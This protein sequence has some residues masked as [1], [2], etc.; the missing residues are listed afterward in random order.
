VGCIPWILLSTSP[1][2]WSILSCM[3]LTCASLFFSTLAVLLGCILVCIQSVGCM[4]DGGSSTG[5]SAGSGVGVVGLVRFTVKYGFA[6]ILFAC[7]LTVSDNFSGYI[8]IEV[9]LD[10]CRR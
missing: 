5:V 9:F 8:V 4:G 10:G 2:V 6:I 1:K 7:S 3:G